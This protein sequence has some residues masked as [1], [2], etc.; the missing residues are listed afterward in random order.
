MRRRWHWRPALNTALLLAFY[1]LP[2][3]RWD[4]RQA[5]LFDLAARRFDLFGLTLWPGD[6]GVLVGLMAVLATTLALLTHLAGRIWCGHACPQTV[7]SGA[8]TWIERGIGRCVRQP[9]WARALTLLAW[10]LLALWTGITFVGLFSPVQAL[11]A[12]VPMLRWRGWEIF[13]VLFYAAATWGNAGFLREQVCRTLCPFARMQPLL[14]DPWTPRMLY[15]PR[16]GEPRGQRPAGLGGV[17][18]RG[19]GLLDPTTAQDYAFRAAH[20]QLAGPM[21]RFPADRLGDCLACDACVAA[22]PV[23]LDI[24][25]GPQADCLA[26]GA[27]QDACDD[28]QR[29][30]GFGRSLVRYRSPATMAGQRGHFM[31]PRTLALLGLLLALLACGAWRLG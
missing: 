30:A 28:V 31:R 21:P 19:R 15:D 27:C 22:C 5:V 13:W 25:Q 8:F 29:S 3:L 14:A 20:P 16:R 23:Q 17:M 2:W 4:G 1:L 26:C 10:A 18:G 6:V 11:L 9:R 24:R 12:G 7:W